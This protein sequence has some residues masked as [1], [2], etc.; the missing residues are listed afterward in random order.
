MSLP[1][2]LTSDRQSEINA[3][4]LADG[5]R[6]ARICPS[7]FLHEFVGHEG[8]KDLV[9]V[10]G[11]NSNTIAK[12]GGDHSS[13]F[14]GAARVL[15]ACEILKVH[16]PLRIVNGSAGLVTFLLPAVTASGESAVLKSLSAC[17]RKSSGH[18]AVVAESCED[19]VITDDEFERIERSTHDVIAAAQAV[20]AEAGRLRVRGKSSKSAK[21][22][23]ANA[24]TVRAR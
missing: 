18:V 19:G 4:I 9:N 5:G 1:K 6:I 20:L 7:E 14:D 21:G 2:R 3:A 12:W 15:A 8:T 23:T 22:G 24:R 13:T 10:T 11:V 16:E 17:M